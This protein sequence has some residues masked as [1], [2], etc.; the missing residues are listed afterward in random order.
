MDVGAFGGRAFAVALLAVWLGA[1]RSYAA[2]GDCSQPVTGGA[3]PM[4]SDCLFILRAAVGSEQCAPECICAPKGALPVTATDALICLK[5]A[6]GQAVALTCACAATT[7]TSSTTTTA[8]GATTTTTTPATTTVPG[9]TTT[10][11]ATTTTV[12]GATTT[13]LPAGTTSTSLG[14]ASTTTT[15]PGATT[16]TIAGVTSSTAPSTT[17]VTDTTTT[18]SLPLLSCTVRFRMTSTDTIG[19]LSFDANYQLIFGFFVG[20][21]EAV[22]CTALAAATFEF[23]NDQASKILTIGVLSAT[24]LGGPADLADCIYETNDPG[25]APE[26]IRIEDVD[27]IS[28]ASAPVDAVVEVASLSCAG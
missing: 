14:G 24:G 15:V 20:D 10:T 28:P 27:A 19:S 25:L 1:A 9:G 8:S 18:T 7:T 2:Q 6:V 4:A 22:Q 26:D 11:I 17:L 3:A 12:A 13:T 5:K 23:A 21:G 16:T